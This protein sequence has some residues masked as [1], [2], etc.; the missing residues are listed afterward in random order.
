[1]EPIEARA[2]HVLLR[3]RVQPKASRNG[4]TWAADGSLRIAVTAAPKEGEANDALAAYV[5]KRLGIAK[6]RVQ[7]AS[8]AH[9]RE[10]A[11]RL[12]GVTAAQV[13]LSFGHPGKQDGREGA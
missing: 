8:G 6:G 11:F 12:E 10:K 4:H 7:L 9:S 5:A 2:D 1:M 3:V 13:Q